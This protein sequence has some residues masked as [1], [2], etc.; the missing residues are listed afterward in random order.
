MEKVLTK[1]AQCERI[2]TDG[3]NKGKQCNMNAGRVGNWKY[4]YKHKNLP[5]KK[6]EHIKPKSSIFLITI[7]SNQQY[8]KMDEDRVKLF[9]NLVKFITDPDEVKQFI[10]IIQGDED[11]IKNIEIKKTFESSTKDLLHSHIYLDIDHNGLIQIKIPKLRAFINKKWGSNVH[12][13][14]QASKNSQKLL[15]AY[16]DKDNLASAE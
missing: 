6:V 2:I 15:E 16:L 11:C 12:L 9:K 10:K 13:N 8:S 4:C 3:P 7:N 5:N 1:K 14:I